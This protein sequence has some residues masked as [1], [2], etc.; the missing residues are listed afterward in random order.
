MAEGLLNF[1]CG[2]GFVAK[3]AGVEKTSVHPLAIKV[4]NEIDI[5]I[6][7]HYSKLIDEFKN[8]TF[9]IVVTVCDQANE[10][11]PF[12]P[13]KKV[14][15]QGFTDPSTVD[16]S[17]EEQLQAF[18]KTR[19]EIK[20]WILKNICDEQSSQDPGEIHDK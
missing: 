15:H 1:Y 18:R 10:T 4:M 20:E 7:R 14:L 16:G 19:D 12:Y 6:S 17:D 5:D 9:D 8:D 2:N 13:G 11:C 3:S